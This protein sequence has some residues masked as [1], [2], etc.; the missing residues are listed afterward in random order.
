MIAGQED[1]GLRRL[2]PSIGWPVT[3]CVLFYGDHP[4]LAKRFFSR[5]VRHT[6]L[7]RLTLRIGC[8][9]ISPA[10]R[11]I[12][13]RYRAEVFSESVLIDSARNLYK[14]VMMR[15]LF[16]DKPI[17]TKWTIWFDDDSYVFRDDWL[18]SLSMGIESHP[19]AVMCGKVFHVHPGEEDLEFVRTAPWFCG[20]P[21]QRSMQR[22]GQTDPVF[23]FIA[24]GFWAIRTSVIAELD[25]PDPR[26]VQRADD[27]LLGEALRQNGLAIFQSYSGVAVNQAERRGPPA[28]SVA[29]RKDLDLDESA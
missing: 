23:T 9:A 3:V 17:E 12:I 21:F 5:L 19:R 28:A 6:P 2:A 22:K 1:D 26:L 25:W 8:N 15:R 7:Q 16:R 13:E 10:T 24:G 20:L 11:D 14:D 4:H 18:Q 27:Y 29:F